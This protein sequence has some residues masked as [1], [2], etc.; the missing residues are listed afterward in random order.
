MKRISEKLSIT[1][2][3]AIKDKSELNKH[4]GFICNSSA[5]W[6]TIRRVGDVVYNLNS[7]NRHMPEIVSE[8]YL[9]AFLM[10]VKEGG[11][12]IFVIDGELPKVDM[13]F[14][15][16]NKNQLWISASKIKSHQEK[17]SKKNKNFQLNISGT[18]EKDMED[19]IKR[20]LGKKLSDDSS[21]GEDENTEGE[22]EKQ[23]EKQFEAYKGVGE[24][25]HSGNV[26]AN[27]SKFETVDPN[28][29]PETF[30][31]IR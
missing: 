15:V 31:L 12:Q 11:Y 13:D 29:D 17:R 4:M 5:H 21:E 18:D 6:F 10:A 19:A 14:D 30:F 1:S 3:D 16:V 23:Q 22:G 9:S 27:Y 20:S 28:E 26:R 7:T 2:I 24:K 25:L 8:F